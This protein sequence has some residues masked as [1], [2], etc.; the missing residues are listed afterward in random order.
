MSKNDDTCMVEDF[1]NV[2]MIEFFDKY[3]HIK[4]KNDK[5]Y[6]IVTSTS[7]DSISAQE[8]I[9]SAVNLETRDDGKDS[10]GRLLDLIGPSRSRIDFITRYVDAVKVTY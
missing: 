6:C 3:I 10:F 5:T 7:T 9:R 4:F 8:A 2:D 1:S